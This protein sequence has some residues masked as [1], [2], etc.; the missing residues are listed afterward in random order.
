VHKLWNIPSSWKLQAQ[1][2]FGQPAGSGPEKE[3]EIKPVE[4]ERVLVFE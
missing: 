3:K 1:L 4:G 2:V